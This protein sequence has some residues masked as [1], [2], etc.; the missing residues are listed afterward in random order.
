VKRRAGFTLLEV[1]IALAFVGLA[2]V[3][4]ISAQG[5]GVKLSGEA[6]FMGRAVYLARQVLA[7]SYDMDFSQGT[8]KDKFDEPL[9]YLGWEREI[10]P[11]PNLPNLYKIQVWVNSQD[12]PIRDG[13]TLYGLVY[14]ETQ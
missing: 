5:Q 14:R 6:R 8:T 7:S 1:M 9:D 2:L 11:V 10:S 4:V 3:A 13:V 12:R